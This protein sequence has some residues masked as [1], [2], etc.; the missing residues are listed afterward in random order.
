[1]TKLPIAGT[2]LVS[3]RTRALETRAGLDI[4]LDLEVVADAAL[5]LER[6]EE[7]ERE[8]E[9]VAA[10]QV[11]GEE[12]G[13]GGVGGGG[14]LAEGGGVVGRVD[15]A[16]EDAADDGGR[17]V[18]HVVGGLAVVLDVGVVGV[19]GAVGLQA[20]PAVLDQA[21]RLVVAVEQRQLA[22]A[23]GAC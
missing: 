1:M 12:A 5:G 9:V 8:L 19:A 17:G 23:A 3:G 20:V 13:L 18:A 15:E 7:V 16:A 14:R 4:L 11:D 21:A 2:E 6:V 10:R 22:V